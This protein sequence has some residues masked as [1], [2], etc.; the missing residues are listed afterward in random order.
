MFKVIHYCLQMYLKSLL[1]DSK[2]LFYAFDKFI[3][4]YE[5]DPVHFLPAPGLAWQACLKRLK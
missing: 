2:D 5:L 4:I 1:F 3:E